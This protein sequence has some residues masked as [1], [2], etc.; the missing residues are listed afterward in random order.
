MCIVKTIIKCFVM[1]FGVKQQKAVSTKRLTMMH[2]AQ[3]QCM[4]QAPFNQ[5]VFKKWYIILTGFIEIWFLR[6][7]RVVSIRNSL[8]RAGYV[9]GFQLRLH[10]AFS[11]IVANFGSTLFFKW[12][13]F[14][15]FRSRWLCMK[16][17]LIIFFWL[18]NSNVCW[19]IAR[20]T[21]TQ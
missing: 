7:F 12:S 3:T 20:T 14:G 4:G 5:F 15:F 19:I 9:L 17:G 10:K 18:M 13:H 21:D 8:I 16:Y 11:S 6:F 1:W 2:M